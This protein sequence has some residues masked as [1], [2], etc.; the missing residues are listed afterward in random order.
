MGSSGGTPSHTYNY[1]SNVP[2]QLI[3]AL[4]QNEAAA[5][6]ASQSPYQAYGGQRI[7]D[8][9]PMRAYAYGQAGNAGQYTDALNTQAAGTIQQGQG[10]ASNLI[11]NTQVHGPQGQYYQMQGPENWDA[12]KAQQYMDPYQQGV[13][14]IAKSSALR[15]Y[16][17]ANNTRDAAS[18]GRGAF[19]GSRS[20]IIQA[21]A[22]RNIGSNLGN[23]QMQGSDRA[24]Q[25]AQQQ[26]G[27]DRAAQMQAGQTNLQAMTSQQQMFNQL[28]QQAEQANMQGRIAGMGALGQQAGMYGQLANSWQNERQGQLD[29]MNRLGTEAQQYNQTQHDQGYND[30]LQARN[31]NQDQLTWMNNMLR[32]TGQTTSTSTPGTNP[33]AQMFGAGLAGV[34]ALQSSSS[35]G[36]KP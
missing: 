36:G 2:S 7:A 11:N 10:A 24:Y 6:Y 34:G 1:Q 14:D 3:P 29:F 17:I 23:L 12:Q 9:D 8:Y 30:W 18:V 32:G 22:D 21:E 28:A 15:D 25:N 4:L 27:A 35:A 33:Y 19:G 13:T 26:F 31:W 16:Q 5:F 20:A